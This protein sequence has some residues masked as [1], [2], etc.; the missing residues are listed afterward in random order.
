MT[1]ASLPSHTLRA[2]IEMVNEKLTADRKPYSLQQDLVKGVNV[3]DADGEYLFSLPEW[4]MEDT[5]TAHVVTL[6]M[7]DAYTNGWQNGYET[8]KE[9]E[10]S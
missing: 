9:E 3:L 5:E 6:A 10:V 7:A 8:A 2:R 1:A 4:A